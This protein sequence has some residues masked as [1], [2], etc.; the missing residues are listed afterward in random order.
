M[1]YRAEDGFW[2]VDI[3]PIPV[4]LV[5][6]AADGAVVT[7]AFSL[8]LERLRTAFTR[9]D[10]FGWSV[11]GW[12]DGHGPFVWI[13]GLCQGRGLFLRVLAHAP[14]GEEAGATLRVP[15]SDD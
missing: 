3:Y 12:A 13:E 14:E 15:E 5:G 7:P 8:D 9:I 10:D 11:L 6:G 1:L 2:E 4:E